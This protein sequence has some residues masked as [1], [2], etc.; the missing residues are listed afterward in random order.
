MKKVIAAFSMIII[1]FVMIAQSD[2]SQF[3]REVRSYSDNYSDNQVIGLYENHYAVPRSTLIQLFSGFGFNWGNVSLGL[4][5]S[6]FLGVPV[7]DLLGVYRQYP[8]GKGW[9]AMA[10]RYGIKPGSPE[11]HRMKAMMGKKNHQWRDIY[12]DYQINRN[13][14]VAR[15]NRV[16]F[17][18]NL[19]R[20]GA[21]SP[22]EMKQ[23]N[24]EIEKRNKEMYKQDKKIVKSWEKENKKNGK[25]RDKIIKEQRK[26]MKKNGKW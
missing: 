8:E 6:N 12:N 9:G 17:N 19:I 14:V 15:R 25:E 11:F 16:Y 13:P 1:S 7:V 10:Q 4:E 20:I 3:T 18:E 22:K 5:I 21:L 26:R 2:Y 24:K 23:I